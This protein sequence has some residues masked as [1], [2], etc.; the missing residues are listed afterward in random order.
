MSCV[1][2]DI[3]RRQREVASEIIKQVGKNVIAG[4]DLLTVTFPVR[5]SAPISMIEFTSRQNAYGPMFLN[6]AS[7]SSDPLERLRL[8][9]TWN[10]ACQHTMS[11][12]LKPF[13]PVLGETYQGCLSDGTMIYAE[14]TSH[15]PPVQTWNVQGPGGCYVYSGWMGYSAKVRFNKVCVT[16]RGSRSVTFPDGA[17]ITIECSSTD[18]YVN[19][20]YGDLRHETLGSCRFVDGHNGLVGFY[21]FVNPQHRRLSPHPFCLQICVGVA[22]RHHRRSH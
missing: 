11:G 15:H 12:F 14:Q 16:T 4:R 13:N 18:Q 2:Q 19:I 3:V 10:I 8:I 5:S 17:C 1:E 6:R 21:R 22:E 9:M 7:A 20:M